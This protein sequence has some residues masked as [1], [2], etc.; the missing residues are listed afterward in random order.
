[1]LRL[2]LWE[3][4]STLMDVLNTMT[5][6]V[7]RP[8]FG[9]SR[10]AEGEAVGVRA[11]VATWVNGVDGAG[12]GVSGTVSGVEGLGAGVGVDGACGVA[13]ASV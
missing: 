7:G 11:G 3:A 13:C 4:I 2:S 10:V 12:V 8:A 9:W 1:M 5:V 6:P